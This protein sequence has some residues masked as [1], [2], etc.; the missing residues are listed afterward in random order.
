MI[1]DNKFTTKEFEET[2]RMFAEQFYNKI[3]ES[4]HA[5][6]KVKVSPRSAELSAIQPSGRVDTWIFDHLTDGS[7]ETTRVLHANHH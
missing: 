2:V 1:T 4:H 5:D 3:N 6:V 7:V